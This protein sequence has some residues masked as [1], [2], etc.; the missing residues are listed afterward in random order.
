MIIQAMTDASPQ[1]GLARLAHL[2]II[3]AEGADAIAFLQGQ[4]TQDF[5]LLPP[6]QARLAAFCSAKGRM[7][8]SFIGFKLSDSGILLLCS[9]E[10]A[11]IRDLGHAALLESETLRSTSG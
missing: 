3:R 10:L 5:A 7:Q 2:G 8:A 4:L 6:D 9:R 11:R 1:Q